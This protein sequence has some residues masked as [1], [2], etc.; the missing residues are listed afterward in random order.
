MYFLDASALVAMAEESGDLWGRLKDA[1]GWQTSRE[2][3]VGLENLMYAPGTTDR[4]RECIG[5]LIQDLPEEKAQTAE[6]T[7]RA[8]SG[9]GGTP[10]FLTAD[11]DSFVQAGEIGMSREFL[12]PPP[13]KHTEHA[14]W[15]EITPTNDQWSALYGGEKGNI[16]ALNAGEY[17]ILLDGEGRAAEAVKWN[18]EK[19]SI[20]NPRGFR[21]Q[22]LGRVAPLDMY[23]RCAFDALACREVVALRGCPGSGKTMI[24]LAYLFDRLEQQA[25]RK[26]YIIGHFEPLKGSRQ[27]GFMR[28]SRREK[29][30]TTGSLGNILAC[31]LGG[32]SS[33]IDLLNTGT[34]EIISAS[35]LRGVE[36]GSEDAVFVTEAQDLDPYTVRTVIQRCKKGCRIIFEGDTRQI[37][38]SRASGFEKMIDV[39]AG[40]ELFA[41]VKLK[42]D[43]RHPLGVLADMIE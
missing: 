34:V 7:W 18:G 2:T 22:M 39:F 12:L 25:V 5:K 16:F 33:V 13:V 24:S 11:Y 9:E 42:E 3:L 37:G 32:E 30:L 31:K 28:G 40:H 19:M 29:Q 38:I 20:V 17:G 1:D 43:H 8:I 36:F 4:R 15:R 14:G 21:S 27:L 41:C 10:V 23:Q 35:D 6:A 26:L